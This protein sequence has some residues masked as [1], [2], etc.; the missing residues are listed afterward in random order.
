MYLE[1]G[2]IQISPLLG[3]NL[4]NE[5]FYFKDKDGMEY[6]MEIWKGSYGFGMAYG[7]EIGI[8]YK[9]PDGKYVYTRFESGIPDWYASVEEPAHL[10]MKNTVW[11]C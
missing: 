1:S 3:M 4:D 9:N 10:K 7:A 2:D 11:G 6:M 5:K 8:Y